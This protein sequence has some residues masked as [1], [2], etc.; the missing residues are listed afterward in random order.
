[1]SVSGIDGLYANLELDQ[2][3]DGLRY[4]HEEQP[5]PTWWAGCRA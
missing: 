4:A 1:M 5:G 2:I 3:Q